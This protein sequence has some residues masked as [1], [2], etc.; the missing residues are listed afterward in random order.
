MNSRIIKGRKNIK[1]GMGEDGKKELERLEC[2]YG[3]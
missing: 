3:T 1:R 2:T